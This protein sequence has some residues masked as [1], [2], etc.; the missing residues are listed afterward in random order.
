MSP[1]QIED[2]AFR[3]ETMPEGLDA[4]EQILFLALRYLYRY[5]RL[6]QMPAEQGKGEKM[7]ILREHE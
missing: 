2:L 7:E 4:A 6:V 5:A 3:G 1:G